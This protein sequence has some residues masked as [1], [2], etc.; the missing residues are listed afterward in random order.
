MYLLF[1]GD[2]YYPRGGW[3]DFKGAFSTLTDA[4]AHALSLNCDWW[5]VAL[6]GVMVDGY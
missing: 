5:H 4:R 1:A 3:R 6:D 2:S